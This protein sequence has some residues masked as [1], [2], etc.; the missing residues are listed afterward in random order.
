MIPAMGGGVCER[1]DY[2]YSQKNLQQKPHPSIP[3]IP[4]I[5]PSIQKR[6][7]KKKEAEKK[8]QIAAPPP[9]AQRQEKKKRPTSKASKAISTQHQTKQTPHDMAWRPRNEGTQ[10]QNR[11]ESSPSISP[12]QKHGRAAAE[13]QDRQDRQEPGRR[14][15]DR[16]TTPNRTEPNQPSPPNRSKPDL[17]HPTH[18]TPTDRPTR[19]NEPARLHHRDVTSPD[20]QPP[21]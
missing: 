1:E 6:R 12:G 10:N 8:K 18:P 16:N 15:T 17:F 21:R 19:P 13:Q 4:S 9:L 20:Q 14:P 2:K 11:G 7:G 5:P 3:S